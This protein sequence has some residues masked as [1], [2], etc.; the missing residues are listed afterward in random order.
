MTIT[1]LE[2]LIDNYDYQYWTLN[3]PTISDPEYDKLIIQLKLLDPS[4]RRLNKIHSAVKNAD[5]IKHTNPMLSL[6]KVY[7]DKDLFKWIDKYARFPNE[8]YLLQPKLDGLSAD[9]EE[10]L[11]STR[12][13]GIYGENLSN[14]IPI[15]TV[16]SHDYTGPMINDP[17]S[18]RR[19]EIVVKKDIYE[20]Y[21]G[22][23]LKGDG[24]IYKTPRGMASG[25][26]N[27]D[28]VDL[29]LT[30][31]L[32][33]IDF[34]NFSVLYTATQLRTLDWFKILSDLK[35]WNYP[36][37]GLV[38]K[39]DDVEYS[40]SLG[41]TTHHPRGQIA[42][43]AGNPFGMAKLLNVI[44]SSGKGKLTPVGLITPV[45]IA[46]AEIKKVSL[47]N[48]KNI[49]NKDIKIGDELT[50]ERA[51]EIIPYV[52]TVIP[53]PEIDRIAITINYCPDCGTPVIYSDPDIKC[54]NDNCNG[55]LSRKLTDSVMRLG[56]E[57][58]AGATIEKLIDIGV[59]N[60]IDI[61]D[62]KLIEIEQLE[63]FADKSSNKLYD[64]IQRIRTIEIED[65]RFLASLN[66][67]GIGRSVS[68]KILN[69]LTFSELEF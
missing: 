5:K 31:I 37:D 63:G 36:T 65:W 44:W 17:K 46:G 45:I 67:K 51:G 59:E 40:N 47:H 19:G 41:S 33:F 64:E 39:L 61:F 2:Q 13:D 35:S 7:N 52:T 32:T 38:I 12:G 68:R 21:K 60:L 66:I 54:P 11:L 62:L 15:I 6:D 53:A 25:L 14:K 34:G 29:S 3:D 30:G 24:T 28:D 26:L 43:K 50:I 16:E 49:I 27:Q 18:N 56:F 58:L 1:E 23:I 42:Y 20:K 22:I 9:K 55:K 69:E 10:Y 57:Y 4:N 8:P 48:A